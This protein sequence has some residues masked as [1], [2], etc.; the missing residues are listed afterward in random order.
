MV[1]PHVDADVQVAPVR[2]PAPSRAVE[3]DERGRYPARVGVADVLRVDAIGHRGADG[4]RSLQRALEN[5]EHRGFGQD[6]GHVQTPNLPDVAPPTP[7]RTQALERSSLPSSRTT[8]RCIAFSV[9]G[10]VAVRY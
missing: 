10:S 5:L 6:G 7:N 4:R 3:H 9:S 8:A 2:V 1:G